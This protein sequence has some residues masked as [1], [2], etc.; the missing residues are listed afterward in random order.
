MF[1]SCDARLVFMQK[2]G[3]ADGEHKS[4]LL[5]REMRCSSPTRPTACYRKGTE[6]KQVDFGYLSPQISLSQRYSISPQQYAI[7]TDRNVSTT[8]FKSSNQLKLL[9]HPCG[10]QL[11]IAQP[12]F[13]AEL[14]HLEQAAFLRG[15]TQPDLTI[16]H[17]QSS[18]RGKESSGQH[19]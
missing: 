17:L 11:A 19:P 9:P 8:L 12:R 3:D 1:A 14:S 13:P 7:G 15:H 5:G 18:R 2:P 16:Q 4:Y 10:H 6:S